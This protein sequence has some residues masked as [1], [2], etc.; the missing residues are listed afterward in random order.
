MK[1][2]YFD[3]RD[4]YNRRLLLFMNRSS[5]I[6]FSKIQR[7]KEGV[8]LLSSD[9]EAWIVKEFPNKTQ[10]VNQIALTNEL[11]RHEFTE[12]YRF[13][14]KPFVFGNR[15][16]GLIQYIEA[17]NETKFTY[18][19]EMNIR[20]A[21]LLLNKFH[22]TTSLLTNSLKTQLPKFNLYTKWE[23]RLADFKKGLQLH[24]NT[25]TYSHLQRLSYYGDW[26]LRKMKQYSDESIKTK[27]CIIHGDVASHNFIRRKN[28]SLYLIDFDLIS[29]APN[30]IDFLQFCNRILPYKE[31]DI[32]KL[33]EYPIIQEYKH[34]KYFLS[35]LVYPA[36]MFREWN[37]YSRKSKL[38]QRLMLNDLEN[39]TLNHYKKR[40][41]FYKNLILQIDN[42]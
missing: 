15:V 35:A 18:E 8:W 40:I 42:D 41:Q 16:F 36:D 29:I 17:T 39:Q 27:N 10:L 33:F 32:E 23:R 9:T 14:P 1:N 13:I 5:G 11:F 38:E 4:G 22:A 28:N 19:N 12:T 26:A 2:N 20:D 34:N 21:L 30:Y 25:K 31:W 6:P 7:I 3:D 24:N 37:Y